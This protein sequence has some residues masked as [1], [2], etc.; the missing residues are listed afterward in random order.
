MHEIMVITVITVVMGVLL[1]DYT[2]VHSAYGN[3][4]NSDNGGPADRLHWDIQL[5]MK[6]CYASSFSYRSCRQSDLHVA[7]C[8]HNPLS[9][10]LLHF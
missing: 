4:D 7:L 1:L 3:G 8:A 10:D 5:G 6:L 2:G 9:H